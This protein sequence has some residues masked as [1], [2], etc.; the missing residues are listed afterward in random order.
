MIC[1][2]KA[3]EDTYRR[4]TWNQAPSPLASRNTTCQDLNGI[5]NLREH[6]EA[7][8]A[9]GGCG[10][11]GGGLFDPSSTGDTTGGDENDISP[12]PR[13]IGG[14]AMRPDVCMQPPTMM[15]NGGDGRSHLPSTM[16]PKNNGNAAMSW[17]YWILSVMVTSLLIN[18]MPYYLNALSTL[19]YDA[20]VQD[21]SSLNN[22]SFHHFEAA[23]T[24]APATMHIA[25]RA[26]TCGEGRAGDKDDY[27]TPLHAGAVVIVWFVSTLSCGFPILAKKLPGLRIPARFFFA[28]RHFGTGVLIATAFVHLLPTAFISL[29]D[30]CLG[31]FWTEDYDAMPGAIALAAIF[32]VAVIEMV[33]HPSRHL[34]T[35]PSTPE[36][37]LEERPI[38]SGAPLRRTCSESTA[39]P[40]R[41][42]APLHGSTANIGYGL[43]HLQ[44]AAPG[45][46]SPIRENQAEAQAANKTI[47][48]GSHES[49][50]SLSVW[51][52]HKLRKER[53]Q[54][55]LLELGILFHSVFIGMA[56]SVSVGSDFVVLLIAIVFH[57]TFEGLALGSRIASVSWGEKTKQPW[58]MAAAYGCTTPI[59]QAIGLA[60]SSLYRPDSEVGL[61]L[62]GIMNAISA[63]LLTY[64]SLVE[65]LSEDFLSDE[66]WRILRGRKR[67]IAC[68]LVFFGAFFM[69]LV[70]AWA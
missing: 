17:V 37:G 8:Q 34:P 14:I 50:T 46:V 5:S 63:G 43:T 44:A 42:M 61:L 62:V 27:N 35:E 21:I 54:C 33:F 23:P 70:G 32:F 7:G 49:A 67:I 2:S 57:Q 24:M 65:L 13:T 29:G 20:P 25:K 52:E 47:Y 39:L 1:L 22:T 26:S 6:V 11:A 59:G 41:G 36:N 60:T 38:P 45:S 10:G 66:S 48:Q 55:V 28:V 31:D 12:G 68:L 3:D 58:L 18:K 15:K 40:L 16:S 4:T 19:V 56:L 51:A 69:S 30:P 64:A 53:L 9:D